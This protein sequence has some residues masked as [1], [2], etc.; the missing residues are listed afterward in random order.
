MAPI[1]DYEREAGLRH[2]NAMQHYETEKDI[3][4]EE[5]KALKSLLKNRQNI[6]NHW[7]R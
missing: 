6:N 1:H 7:R 3:W 4:E 2:E 5:L